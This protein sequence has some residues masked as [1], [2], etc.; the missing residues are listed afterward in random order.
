MERGS[1][2]AAILERML[3]TAGEKWGSE[4]A[5]SFRSALERA[6]ELV[7]VVEGFKLDPEAEPAHP[8]TLLQQVIRQQEKRI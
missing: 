4:R 1:E 7:W 5:E 8:T 2:K 3:K 6:V